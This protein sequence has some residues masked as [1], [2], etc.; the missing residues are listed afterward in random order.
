MDPVLIAHRDTTLL[1][2]FQYEFTG[3][4]YL[5]EIYLLNG[6]LDRISLTSLSGIEGPSAKYD[7]DSGSFICSFPHGYREESLEEL[8]KQIKNCRVVCGYIRDHLEELILTGY[9]KDR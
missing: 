5:A 4:R 8:E 3:K 1:E 2:M 9:D 7:P 6:I